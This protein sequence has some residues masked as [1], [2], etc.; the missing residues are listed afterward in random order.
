MKAK[1]CCASLA[2]L[3]AAATTGYGG[4]YSI[5]NYDLV[6]IDPWY[7]TRTVIG[8]GGPLLSA[9]EYSVDGFIYGVNPV[10]DTLE[11]IDPATGLTETIGPLGFDLDWLADLDEDAQGQ[12]WMLVPGPGRLY[13]IDRTSGAATLD[14][15]ADDI[16]ITGLV[17]IGDTMYT[18]T[19]AQNPPPGPGCGLEYLGGPVLYLELGPD[20]W[21]NGLY[22]QWVTWHWGYDIFYRMNPTSGEYQELGR[23]FSGLTDS[24]WSLTFDPTEQPPSAR[25][26]P[27]LEWPGRALMIILL[28]LAGIGVIRGI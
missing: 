5:H 27:I 16:E 19:W 6:K 21:V 20:G 3:A 17:S 18:T 10:A 11:R 4:P 28:A 15:Q 1:L 23:F 2:I 12:L 14:C 26:I 9:I 8:T 22:Y 13:S 7:Q 25:P 24:M